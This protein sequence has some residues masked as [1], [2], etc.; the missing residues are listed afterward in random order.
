[1]RLLQEQG[2]MEQPLMC[3]LQRPFPAGKQ[4]C[5]GTGEQ[6]SEIQNTLSKITAVPR[7]KVTPSPG[8]LRSHCPGTAAPPLRSL[9]APQLLCSSPGVNFELRPLCRYTLSFRREIS[10]ELIL[11]TTSLSI[12]LSRAWTPPLDKSKSHRTLPPTPKS[13]TPVIQKYGL[14]YPSFLHFLISINFLIILGGKANNII[15]QLWWQQNFI[16]RR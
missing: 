11:G 8:H 12:L 15:R 5:E 14:T 13:D 3:C 4:I 10:K 2:N 1:M 16:I 6:I 9:Q 7:S